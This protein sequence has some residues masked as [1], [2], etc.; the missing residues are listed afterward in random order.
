MGCC[1][2]NKPKW[3]REIVPDHKF[4]NVNLDAFYD[5]SC[6]TRFSYSFVFVVF[7]KTVCVISADLY[8][9]VSLLVIGQTTVTPAIPTEYSKWIFLICIM[10]SYLLIIWD[11]IKSRRILVSKDISGAFTSAIVNKYLSIKDYR[12]FCLFK[13]IS[14]NSKGNDNYAFFIL[15]TL[16]GWKRLLLAEAPRQVINIVTL[17]ALVP[18]W[19][20]IRNGQVTFHNEALGDD[21]MQQILTGTMAFSVVVFAI[22]FLLVCIA[23][24]LY[25]PLFCHIRGNLK[26]YCCHKVDKRISEILRKQGQ[27]RRNKIVHPEVESLISEKSY[28]RPLMAQSNSSSPSLVS[29]D[30]FEKSPYFKHNESNSG[31]F[32]QPKSPQRFMEKGQPNQYAYQ[33]RRYLTPT[34]ETSAAY[35]PANSSIPSSTC[36]NEHRYQHRKYPRGY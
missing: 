21:L 30:C 10:V 31:Y 36:V 23:A 4:E 25:I 6:T 7:L 19:M 34:S 9:A 33:N 17:Q 14:S 24:I 2:S 27:G 20:K 12:Y 22:S 3:K 29:V 1:G 28:M 8:T 15:F 32:N 16:K 26:E 5:S 13:S 18:Q 11:L 35:N